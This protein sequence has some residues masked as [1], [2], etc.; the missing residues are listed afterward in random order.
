MIEIVW[1][2]ILIV[3]ASFY[4][5]V[6]KNPDKIKN[7]KENIFVASFYGIVLSLAYIGTILALGIF[8]G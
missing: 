6:V 1:F 7:K 2:Q 3:I 8:F 5:F 4:I